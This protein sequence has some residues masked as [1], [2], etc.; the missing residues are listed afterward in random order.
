M[1]KTLPPAPNN[2]PISPEERDRLFAP[3]V[4]RPLALCVS[5]GADSMAL[6]HLVSE[7]AAAGKHSYTA[8]FSNPYGLPPR[9]H[10][11][12]DK[13]PEPTWLKGGR[14]SED[15]L[16]SGGPAPIV[17]LTVN[18]GLRPE[19][20]EEAEFVARVAGALG[21]PHQILHADE[22]APKSGIQEWARN[23][24][25]RLIL[26]LLDAEAWRYFELGL[27]ETDQIRRLVVMAH[28]LDDQAETVLMRL[29]RGSSL[30]GL[31]GIHQFDG[32]ACKPNTA[33]NYTVSADAL[34]PFLAIPKSRLVETLK[35]RG[36]AFIDD[37]SNSYDRFERV[38]VR[39]A[40]QILQEVGFTAKAIVRS[41]TRL[42]QADESL[43][44]FERRW[45]K[46]IIDWN[47]G[48]LASVAS[49][50]F[51]LRAEFAET[52][53]LAVLIA[54]YGGNA[55]PAELSQV[56]RLR[57]SLM[58]EEGPFKGSTLGGCRIELSGDY[59]GGRLLI[60]REGNGNGLEAVPISAGQLIE[61]DG[62]RFRIEADD[63]APKS[64][65]V[66]A[67]GAEGWV[68]LKKRIAG[69]DELKLKAAAISTMPS[70]WQG[71]EIIAMPFLETILR[72]RNVPP[73]AR[74]AWEK[75]KLPQ[76]GR[77]KAMFTGLISA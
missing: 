62:D 16:A 58:G 1:A 45:H 74:A 18:H 73:K 9:R 75:F 27:D 12:P 43:Y 8:D 38:R 72:E 33:P 3:L 10:R 13:M 26:E 48:L 76:T 17:V 7:W 64:A 11:R 36:V 20:A 23:L 61:W 63:T 59:E 47:G 44:A 37:P 29:A 56:E 53:L 60:Y 55:R 14:S 24:R 65:E 19:A 4:G 31:G 77:Y 5:G 67:L 21:L 71:N 46:Q 66:R 40:L 69:L 42:Q 51:A 41:A 25:R 68:Q 6:L 39:K 49:P 32:F 70:I 35:E 34:R 15:L 28:H 50:E 30:T 54:A 57:R 52:R 2:E 22:P